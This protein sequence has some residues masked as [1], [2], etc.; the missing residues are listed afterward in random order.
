MSLLRDVLTEH[1]PCDRDTA[2]K[3]AATSLGYQRVRSN[4]AESLS[5]AI[6]TAVKR[7]VLLNGGSTLSV[8]RASVADYDK[9]FLKTQFLAALSEQGRVWTDRN[10]A[11]RAFARWLGFCRIGSKIDETARSLINGLLREG[12]LEKDGDT[13]RRK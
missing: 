7:Q 8:N 13:I 12:R 5:N 3:Q 1:G 11:I 10:E 9:D 6:R 2:I 4:V